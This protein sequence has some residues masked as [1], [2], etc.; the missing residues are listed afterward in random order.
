[1]MFRV[2]FVLKF[3]GQKQNILYFCVLEVIRA[4]FFRLQTVQSQT[5]ALNRG[6]LCPYFA[7]CF[8]TKHQNQK[9]WR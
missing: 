5:E 1:M 2:F 9:K 6:C 4:K 7:K 8:G 3:L